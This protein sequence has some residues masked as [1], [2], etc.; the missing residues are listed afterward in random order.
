MWG[1]VWV[2]IPL[3]A[4][5]G[6]IFTRWHKT[7]A[8]LV[9]AQAGNTEAMQ[10]LRELVLRLERRVANLERAVMTAEEQRKY[11]L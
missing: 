2:L 7:N 6:G 11:V 4:I 9:L 8:A 10:E 5:V 3:A 1:M